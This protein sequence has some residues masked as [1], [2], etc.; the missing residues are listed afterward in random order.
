MINRFPTN[1]I[2]HK[3]NLKAAPLSQV[4]RFICLYQN[5]CPHS[6]RGLSWHCIHLQ[7]WCFRPFVNSG[8]EKRHHRT[9]NPSQ[10]SKRLIIVTK[11]VYP[12]RLNKS[13]SSSL[14]TNAIGDSHSII[15]ICPY[16]RHFIYKGQREKSYVNFW[17]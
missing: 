9:V 3:I 4:L 8:K 13:P 17:S 11:L 12:L 10:V 14:L 15:Y 16:Y 6:S 2:Y 7:Q 5:L 1:T